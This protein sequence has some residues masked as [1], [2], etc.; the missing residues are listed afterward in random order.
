MG[1][2]Y[3]QQMFALIRFKIWTETIA[4]SFTFVQLPFRSN[5]ERRLSET[6]SRP[7]VT[8]PTDELCSQ[9]PWSY[10]GPRNKP[11]VPKPKPESVVEEDLEM[12]PIPLPDYTLHFSPT[13][14]NWADEGTSVTDSVVGHRG[15]SATGVDRRSSCKH[16]TWSKVGGQG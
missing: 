8:T 13:A 15:T 1:I 5:T 11:I 2:F 6:P 4:L 16:S 14:V 9:L 10:F 12:P 7:S 3:P